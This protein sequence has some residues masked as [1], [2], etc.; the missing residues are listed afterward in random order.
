MKKSILIIFFLLAFLERTLYDLGPNI[1][2]VTT[3]MILSSF[4][5]GKKETLFLV[6]LIMLFSDIVIGN[7]NIFLFTWTGF[8]IPVLFSQKIIN[9][10][11]CLL[12]PSVKKASSPLSLAAT[13]LSANLFFFFW[14][15]F[16]VW[17]ISGM[18]SK[19]LTGLL[20]SYINA[21][22]FLRYQAIST[23][24]FVPSGFLLI[25]AVFY[26]ANKYNLSFKVTSLPN[27][28]RN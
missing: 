22:P 14:T 2:L 11:S 19:T 21:L 26:L 25:K 13:G 23:L 8:L 16:G 28:I 17:L 24:I 5:Y 12:K 1:E 4:F 9:K 20:M 15:N 3:A 18:Y 6:F 10:F 7:T 27:S